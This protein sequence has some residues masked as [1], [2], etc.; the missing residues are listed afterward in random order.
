MI[1]SSLFS[2]NYLSVSKPYKYYLDWFVVRAL[3]DFMSVNIIFRAIILLLWN[4]DWNMIPHKIVLF[5]RYD[6]Q[7]H[8]NKPSAWITSSNLLEKYL[9]MSLYIFVKRRL[10][11]SKYHY[12]KWRRFKATAKGFF[13]FSKT[14]SILPIFYKMLFANGF[15]SK[16]IIE[17]TSWQTLKK[18]FRRINRTNFEE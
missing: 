4:F 10:F 1:F 7:C 2:R 6:V 17:L 8:G 18:I 3:C 15:C 9:C 5:S 12:L 13:F 14:I 16:F 11:F